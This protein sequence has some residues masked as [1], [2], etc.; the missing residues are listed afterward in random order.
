MQVLSSQQAITATADTW[1]S[2]VQLVREN[3]PKL[4]RGCVYYKNGDDAL[5]YLSLFELQSGGK[6]LIG[7]APELYR[8]L[9]RVIGGEYD[10]QREFVLLVRR[11]SEDGLKF[12][13][14]IQPLTD[15]G[16]KLIVP[17]EQLKR[18]ELLLQKAGALKHLEELREKR[19][20]KHKRRK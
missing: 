19:K 15:D 5:E 11:Q 14:Q 4:G 8:E 13:V 10:F 3:N 20:P 9:L 17:P 1:A 12:I 18:Q 7:I 2:M 6:E 16:W